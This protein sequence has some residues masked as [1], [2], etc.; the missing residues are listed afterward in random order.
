MVR[1]PTGPAIC[2]FVTA[3]CLRRADRADLRTNGSAVRVVL[4]A[5]ELDACPTGVVTSAAARL[6]QS[7]STTGSSSNRVATA[8]VRGEKWGGVVDRG[9][10]W[11]AEWGPV[12]TVPGPNE[13]ADRERSEEGCGFGA[14][15]VGVHERQ[16]DDKGRLALPSAFR[17]MLGDSCY[18]AFG[19]D[20]C[21]NVFAREDFEGVARDLMHQVRRN[22]ITL[23]RQRAL[24]H[25]ATL[26]TLDK[27]GR[28]TIDEKLRTYARLQPSH[29][30]RR[31][32]Q[33]R[34]RRGVVRGALR[35]DRRGRPRRARRRPG[36]S[37]APTP[38]VSTEGGAR[39]HDEPATR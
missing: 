29:E 30:G 21:I 26:V 39:T 5:R 32:R 28:V 3:R 8:G 36:V 16:L 22:E 15:F 37:A 23:T 38:T 33:P 19:E 14:M 27:Q 13:A 12:G 9:G 17:S 25:S 7:S 10:I 20:R 31:L 18:L 35:A 2:G 6:L 34:P 11:G 24:A 4:Q 1:L